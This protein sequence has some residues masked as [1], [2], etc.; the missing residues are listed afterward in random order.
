MKKHNY[1]TYERC[2]DMAKLCKTRTEFKKLYPSAV[3]K[4][5]DNKWM[6]DICSHMIKIG[7]YKKRCIYV[8]IF[9]DHYA[10]V[11]LTYNFNIRINSHIKDINSSIYKHINKTGLKPRFEKLTDYV[12]I[13]IA[14]T[15]LEEFFK[16][17]YEGLGFKM[18]NIAK[19]GGVGG[20]IPKYTKE[21]CQKESLKYLTRGEFSKFSNFYNV[22]FRNGWLDDVCSH[23]IELKKPKGYWTKE[24]CENFSL[25]C[26]SLK[27]F[28][29]K[30]NT[31]YISS[32]RYGWI[33]DITK[34]MEKPKPYNYKWSKEECEKEYLKYNNI[35]DF[36]KYSKYAYKT[37]I[38][39]HWLEITKESDK[40]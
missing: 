26:N 13:N 39:N 5:Y 27:E 29:E 20:N 35:K 30:Y 36:K 12:D 15:K 32:R 23:M 22:S 11:G 8:A 37:I 4:S 14:S 38:N 19:T 9:S 6:D 3:D 17:H 24:K 28:E 31:S 10:Y 25:K 34:H 16:T 2:K 7:N 1:W 21:D 40:E 33:K 18:L